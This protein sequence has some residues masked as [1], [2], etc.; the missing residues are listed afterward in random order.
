MTLRERLTKFQLELN[1]QFH[2]HSQD[3]AVKV[4]VFCREYLALKEHC[5]A[6]RSHASAPLDEDGESFRESA[7]ATLC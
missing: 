6:S 3:W 7:T 5:L 4:S 2:A 1:G